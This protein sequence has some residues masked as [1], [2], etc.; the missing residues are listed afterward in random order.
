[1]DLDETTFVTIGNEVSHLG[2]PREYSVDPD[3]V[4]QTP[5]TGALPEIQVQV[6]SGQRSVTP[7]IP[8]PSFTGFHSAQSGQTPG[9][10]SNLE[11]HTLVGGETPSA[12]MNREEGPSMLSYTSAN[13]SFED[14]PE[15]AQTP[16]QQERQVVENLAPHGDSVE[17][18]S[19]PQ[20]GSLLSTIRSNDVVPSSQ[21]AKGQSIKKEKPS[22]APPTSG[23]SWADILARLKGG[24]GADQTLNDTDSDL[25]ISDRSPEPEEGEEPGTPGSSSKHSS[26]HNSSTGTGND[27]S[28]PTDPTHLLNFF[29][30][31]ASTRSQKSR[32]RDSILAQISEP[33]LPVGSQF[34]ASQASQVID[35]TSSPHGSPEPE[36]QTTPS[37][38]TRTERLKKPE[39]PRTELPR[40]STGQL[41]PTVEIPVSPAPSRKRRRTTRKF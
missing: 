32:V 40:A 7:P 14:T 20:S 28:N 10:Y 37:R 27:L 9:L 23:E 34:S 26:P 24:P 30:P 15:E 8:S 19:G 12:A 25:D 4:Q 5:G 22:G 1:M 33:Q 13:Q 2:S 39:S 41:Q 16:D 3:E 21:H 18:G 17:S 29:S 31:A 36:S 6:G 38:R 35:L 11:G